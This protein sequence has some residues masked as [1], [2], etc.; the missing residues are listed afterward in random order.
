MDLIRENGWICNSYRATKDTIAVSIISVILAVAGV[1]VLRGDNVAG[2][3]QFT[4]WFLILLLP[5]TML[6]LL[7]VPNGKDIILCSIKAKQLQIFSDCIQINKKSIPVRTIKDIS[8]ISR[9]FSRY[10]NYRNGINYAYK[11]TFKYP[12][13]GLGKNAYFLI[14][15]PEGVDGSISNFF[16]QTVKQNLNLPTD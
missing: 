14:Q 6:L 5:I 2:S 4:A 10:E 15:F 16:I 1:I 3:D 13:E 8:S 12:V 7:C 9:W 11:I